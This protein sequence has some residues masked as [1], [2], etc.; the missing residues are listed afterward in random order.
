M[1]LATKIER[2]FKQIKQTTHAT[3]CVMANSM[4]LKKGFWL[5]IEEQCHHV[6]TCQRG[7]GVD[8]Q[9]VG[10]EKC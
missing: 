7:G 3:A 9:L 6:Q 5:K 2:G 1:V 8:L 10:F 4:S